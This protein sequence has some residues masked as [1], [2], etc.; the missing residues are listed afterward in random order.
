MKRPFYEYDEGGVTHGG[1]GS[2]DCV[3]PIEYGHHPMIHRREWKN[4]RAYLR[5]NMAEKVMHWS[6]GKIRPRMKGEDDWGIY[7]PWWVTGIG[8][9]S[10]WLFGSA[11]DDRDNTTYLPVH[12]TLSIYGDKTEES[13]WWQGRIDE[14]NK[15]EGK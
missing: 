11:L 3:P 15:Q 5:N 10:A 9:V 6:F 13:V 4:R 8:R 2:C 12:P 1:D 7:V 14:R